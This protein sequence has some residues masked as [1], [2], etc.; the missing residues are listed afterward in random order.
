MRRVLQARSGERGSG[1][2]RG[3]GVLAVAGAAVGGRLVVKVYVMQLS[4]FIFHIVEVP[5]AV[6]D[7]V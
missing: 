1:V 7:G 6:L 4:F 2:L 5:R 3:Q